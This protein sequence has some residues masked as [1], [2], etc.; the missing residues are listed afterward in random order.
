MFTDRQSDVRRESHV[1]GILLSVA[2][3]DTVFAISLF[4]PPGADALWLHDDLD[5]LIFL[6]FEYLV[7]TRRLFEAHLVGDNKRWV[8]LALLNAGKQGL[9]IPLN[10]RLAHFKGQTLRKSRAKR[11]LVQ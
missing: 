4:S 5:A 7:S 8:D 6:L 2:P 9:Q 1:T 10:M 3:V 11:D